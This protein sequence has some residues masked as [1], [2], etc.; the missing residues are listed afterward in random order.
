MKILL[1][2]ILLN[3]ILYYRT[4]KYEGICDDIPVFTQNVEIPKGWLNYKW[5][6]FWYHLHGRKYKSWKYAHWQVIGIHTINCILIYLAFGRNTVSMLAALL[7]AVNPVNNQGSI[8]ISGKGYAMNTTCALLMW[9]FP[10]Y[11]VIPYLFGTYF[12]GA[13][14]VLF[15]LIFLFT[16]Y[17]WLS[18]L[19]IWGLYREKDRIFNKT[20]PSSKFN[21]ES[22]KELKAIKPRKLILAFKTYA[23]HFINSVS[24]RILSLYHKYMFLMGVSPKEN[25]KC[26]K[27]DWYFFFGILLAGVTLYTRHIGLLWFSVSIVSWINIISFNQTIANRYVYSANVGLMYLLAILIAP[28]PPIIVGFLVYYITKLIFFMKAYHNEY[29]SIEYACWEQPNFFYSWQNRAAHCFLNRNYHG[30]LGNTLKAMEIRKDDWKLTYNLTQIYMILG[31][32]P[33]AKET[34]Q[35][36]AKLNIDGREEQIKGLMDRLGGWIDSIEKQAKEQNNRVDI[37]LLKFDMQR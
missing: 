15:P 12:C 11:S 21:T 30:A 25:E 20:D 3:L 18:L 2:I 17:W 23:Y 34:F 13:S 14:L 6:Y 4:T 7:F 24:A 16:K 32:L 35:K 26:Y 37:D 8:W 36:A 29:W 33:L 9:M 28:Y 27:L 5:M 19:V 31:H 10:A 1:I 22:N